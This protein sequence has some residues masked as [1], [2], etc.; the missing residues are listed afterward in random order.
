MKLAI[1]NA[2]PVVA[3]AM[4]RLVLSTDEHVVLWLAHDGAA[5]VR[6]CALA[7][8]DLLLMDVLLPILD[9]VEATRRIMAETPCSIVVVTAEVNRIAGRV[10]EAMGAGALDAVSLTLLREEIAPQSG[11]GL[12]AKIETIRHLTGKP[13]AAAPGRHVVTNPARPVTVRR[14]LVVIGASAG[15]PAAVARVVG[16]WPASFPAA[17]IVVQHVDPRFASGLADW[18][19]SHTKLS[20]RVAREGDLPRPGTLLMAG[21][22]DH[23]VLTEQGR[24]AYTRQPSGLSIRPSVDV[25]FKSIV[26]HWQGEV[27]AVLLTG[28]GQDGAAGLRLLREAGHH[29][30]AQDEATSAVYGMPKAAAGLRAACEILPLDSIAPR[31]SVRLA[32]HPGP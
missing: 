30:I 24:L 9:G 15:G 1:V 3:E 23:L 20:V 11:A 21:A 8:P 19:A 32:Q 25:F 29:T 7:R 5:A 14:R 12:L 13:A 2:S 4:R 27:I 22:A 17:V 16:G 10:F 26:K 6:R 31:V 28:M 18:L